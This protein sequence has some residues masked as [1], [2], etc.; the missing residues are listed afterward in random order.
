VRLVAKVYE[1]DGCAHVVFASGVK[2]DL[3]TVDLMFDAWKIVY[4]DELR[5][6]CDRTKAKTVKATFTDGGGI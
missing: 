4:N 5:V 1:E 2:P 6:Y 3:E